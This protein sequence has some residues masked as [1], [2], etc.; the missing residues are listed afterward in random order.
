MAESQFNIWYKYLGQ[1][2]T[3]ENIYAFFEALD[4]YNSTLSI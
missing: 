4:H 3:L 2:T 1:I